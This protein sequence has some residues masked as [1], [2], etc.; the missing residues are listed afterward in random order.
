LEHFASKLNLDY[1]KDA[2]KQYGKPC[3]VLSV[4]QQFE[5]FNG[6]NSREIEKK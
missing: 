6:Q 5:L 3:D 2:L 1:K 4:G